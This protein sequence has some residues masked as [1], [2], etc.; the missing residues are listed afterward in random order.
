[1]KA[2]ITAGVKDEDL[3]KEIRMN[4][5][6]SSL[7]RKRIKELVAAKERAAVV[8]AVSSSAYDSPSWALK[9]ADTVGYIRA[10][11]ECIDLL[12]D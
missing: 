11:R 9:Q 5:I 10:L 4:F 12:E 3:V 1:M 7:I 2:N 6:S 8:N